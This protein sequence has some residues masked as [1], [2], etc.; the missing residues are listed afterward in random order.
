MESL[1]STGIVP[2]PGSVSGR[3]NRAVFV[4]I[5]VD[6]IQHQVRLSASANPTKGPSGLSGK[7]CLSTFLLESIVVTSMRQTLRIS[8]GFFD[9][10]ELLYVRHGVQIQR[11]RVYS[12][13][14]VVLRFSF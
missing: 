4:G 9:K 12:C 8:R 1:R 2:Q 13:S 11:I 10:G 7:R 14:F 3:K 5:L 6:V